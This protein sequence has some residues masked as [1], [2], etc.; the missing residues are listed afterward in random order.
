MS[1]VHPHG[2]GELKPLLASGLALANAQARAATL[3][4][5]TVS[6]REKGDLVMLGIGGFTPLPGFMSQADWRGVCDNMHLASGLFW[7]IPITLSCDAAFAR[8]LKSGAEIALMD[9]EDGSCLAL[10]TVNEQYTIDKAHECAAVFK[11]T[12]LEH[13]GVKMVMAQGE[14]NLAGPVRVLS[15]GGFKAKYG[16]L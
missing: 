5:L 12:E 4:K 11:T 1:L 14:V 6:S 9:P 3:P 10:M 15:D 8:G 7:P 16:A 2:A 13:P